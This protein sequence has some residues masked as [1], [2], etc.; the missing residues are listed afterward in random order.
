LAVDSRQLTIAF[1]QHVASGAGRVAL[2]VDRGEPPVSVLLALDRFSLE[3]LGLEAPYAEG[4]ELVLALTAAELALDEGLRE[5]EGVLEMPAAQ[6]PDLSAYDPLLPDSLGLTLSGSGRLSGRVELGGRDD[7]GLRAALDLVS[8]DL[9]LRSGERRI[10]G[11][12]EM[13]TRLRGTGQRLYDLAGSEVQLEIVRAS[14]GEEIIA[15]APQP[16]R[17]TLFLSEGT[18]SAAAPLEVRGRVRAE[19]AD[20]G[21][22]VALLAEQKLLVNWFQDALTVRDVVAEASLQVGPGL[23]ALE[24]LDV[25]GAE[26][27]ILGDLTLQPPPRN[28]LLFL[29]LGRLS[30]GLRLDGEV[31]DWKLTGSR[32]WFEEARSARGA[33]DQD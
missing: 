11:D 27:E 5:V 29:R 24:D 26:L 3:R 19:L 9:V 18:L 6:V 20:S 23:F 22:L 15:P 31:R 14:D 1:L 32:R 25:A 21:P 10:P 2:S 7:R 16:W 13:R 8:R 28:G 33:G 12:L 30:A 4:S 17:G